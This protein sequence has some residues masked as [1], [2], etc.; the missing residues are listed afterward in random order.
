L[1]CASAL[2]R[3]SLELDVAACEPE[4][5]ADD[6]EGFARDTEPDTWVDELAAIAPCCAPEEPDADA[7][8]PPC[9]CTVACAWRSAGTMMSDAANVIFLMLLP[10]LFE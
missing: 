10:L 9:A 4:A 1:L 7:F 5:D 6:C 2:R 8:T 3:R